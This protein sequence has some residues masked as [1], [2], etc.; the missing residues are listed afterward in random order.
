[1]TFS[2][3]RAARSRS[4]RICVGAGP[5]RQDLLVHDEEVVDLGD[6]TEF[7]TVPSRILAGLAPR[8]SL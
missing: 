1:L 5:D 6:G 7:V 3:Q 8:N 4:A 2:D